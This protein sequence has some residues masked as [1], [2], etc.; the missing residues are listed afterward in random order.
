MRSRYTLLREVRAPGDVLLLLRA[1]SMMALVPALMWLSPSTLAVLLERVP[2]ATR[3]R[4]RTQQRARPIVDALLALMAPLVTHRCQLRALTLYYL[5]RRAGSDV[6]LAF[7]VADSPRFTEGHCWLTSEGEPYLERRDPR[8]VFV[9]L[10]RI[11]RERA[12]LARGRHRVGA[13]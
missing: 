3:A 13:R 9:E 7:G 6:G 1:A 2:V 5:L 8:P 4:A 10:Y 12:S 11:P